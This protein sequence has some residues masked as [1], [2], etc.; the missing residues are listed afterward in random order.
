MKARAAAPA[1]IRPAIKT[2]P[3]LIEHAAPAFAGDAAAVTAGTLNPHILL[4]DQAANSLNV[5]F[6]GLRYNRG[7]P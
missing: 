4:F 2:G 5:C 1:K 6:V 7:H 3:D